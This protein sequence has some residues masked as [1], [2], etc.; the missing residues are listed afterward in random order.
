VRGAARRP[1]G[2]LLP[3]PEAD[4]P[5]AESYTGMQR[6]LTDPLENN[7]EVIEIVPSESGY[8]VKYLVDG[9][10]VYRRFGEQDVGGCR[11]DIPEG[12]G[13]VGRERTA[14]TTNQHTKAEHQ[15]AP[16]KLSILTRGSTAG[17]SAR[18]IT[19]PKKRHDFNIEKL[20]M[21]PDQVDL[22]RNSMKE[23]GGGVV[24]LSSPKGSGLT[25]LSY[26]VL[27]SHGCVPRTHYDL[28]ARPG[29]GP[30]RHYAA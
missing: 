27:K 6:M 26:A 14:Q 21:Q 22:I 30:G 8:V 3:A 12:G 10:C 15:Q 11:V 19:N 24:L 20:G 28:G 17:E 1:G 9:V 7:C 16:A 4:T 23:E 5:E 13:G 29:A 25:S 2:S 18:L